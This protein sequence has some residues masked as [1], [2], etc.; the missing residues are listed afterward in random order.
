M[1]LKR[2][3]RVQKNENKYYQVLLSVFLALFVILASVK[4]TLSFKYLYYYDIENLKIEDKSGYSREEI[5]ENYNYVVNY[6]L[7]YDKEY[8]EFN[9]PSIEFSE[10]GKIHF[11][12]VKRIFVGIDILI[13]ASLVISLIGIFICKRK[14]RIDYIKYTYRLLIT[15]PVILAITIYIN[16]DKAF[17]VFHKMFF[18]NNYW[19]FNRKI[20]PIINILP[21]EF[22]MHASLMIISNIIIFSIV[23][24]ILYKYIIKKKSSYN[25]HNFNI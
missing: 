8:S 25:Q 16:F 7:S 17:V 3:C 24:I 13:V 2:S 12:D 11:E 19:I 1:N 10:Y 21:Q 14:Q 5:V 4:L 23:L 22:F 20:D 6:L 15:L 9:L 18:N